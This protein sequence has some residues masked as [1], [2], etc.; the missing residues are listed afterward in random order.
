MKN[1]LLPLAL[2]ISTSIIAGIIFMLTT[3]YLKNQA[4]QGCMEVSVYRSERIQDGMT[5]TTEEPIKTTVENCLQIKG[6]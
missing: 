3:Q 1:I 6:Y 2:I 5:I 4:V